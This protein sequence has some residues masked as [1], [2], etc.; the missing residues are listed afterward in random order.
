VYSLDNNND[1]LGDRLLQAAKRGDMDRIERLLKKGADVNYY[2]EHKESIDGS[3]E[4]ALHYLCQSPECFESA[5]ELL[6]N[7]GAVIEGHDK[8]NR[9]VLDFACHSLFEDDIICLIL[10][11]IKLKKKNRRLSYL[12]AGY[13]E[14]HDWEEDFCPL[15]SA[16][17]AK[18]SSATLMMVEMGAETDVVEDMQD[19][20]KQLVYDGV[21]ARGFAED[22]EMEEEDEEEEEDD[23][24][25]EESDEDEDEDEDDVESVDE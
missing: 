16:V 22:E 21:I 18:L 2:D 15:S 1:R 6:L 11:Q 19:E 3:C 14:G 24:E 7:H 8:F 9:G 23:E 25:E 5:Y 10:K 20:L 13:S 17:L 12:N 4:T